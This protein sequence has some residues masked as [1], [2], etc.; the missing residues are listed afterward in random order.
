MWLHFIA[1]DVV[2]PPPPKISRP[3]TPPPPA[4][5]SGDSSAA[6][7][8]A[9][10][11]QSLSIEETNKLRARLGLKPLRIEDIPA[12]KEDGAEKKKE[13]EKEGGTDMGEFVHKPAGKLSV[14]R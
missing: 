6:P 5:S 4:I 9:R 1:D 2:V 8:S 3:S 14:L 12:F 10:S 11:D 7:V 13:V